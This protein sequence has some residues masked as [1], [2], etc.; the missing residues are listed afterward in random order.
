MS[1]M[2]GCSYCDTRTR[3]ETDTAGHRV[4]QECGSTNGVVGML[5]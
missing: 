5:L 2:F 4:C 3:H 1:Y